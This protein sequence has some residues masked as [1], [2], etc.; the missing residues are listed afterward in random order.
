MIYVLVNVKLVLSPVIP[1]SP[2]LIHMNTTV[3]YRPLIHRLSRSASDNYDR[4]Q[5]EYV[6]NSRGKAKKHN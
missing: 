6:V 4:K 1:A 5:Q 2:S 3:S